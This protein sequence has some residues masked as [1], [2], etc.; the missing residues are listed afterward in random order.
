MLLIAVGNYPGARVT[1]IF[2]EEDSRKAVWIVCFLVTMCGRHRHRA[3]EML[4][5][6]GSSCWTKEGFC[7]DHV[8]RCSSVS[9]QEAEAMKLS[10]VENTTTAIIER[11][12]SFVDIM[13]VL[14]NYTGSFEL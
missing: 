1:S 13:K 14:I 2:E 3:N 4:K 6:E 8:I 7:V 10:Q 12:M 5:E 9:I 11:E